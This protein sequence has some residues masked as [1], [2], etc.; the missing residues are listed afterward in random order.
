M[1]SYTLNNISQQKY[2]FFTGKGGVGKTSIA[3]ATAISLADSGENVL[4]I[5]TDPASNLQDVFEQNIS[6]HGTKI[7]DVPRLTVVNL[8]PVEAAE[9]YKDDLAATT[10]TTTAATT[11]IM[12]VG[13]RGRMGWYD[14]QV[15]TCPFAYLSR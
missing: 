15:L 10:I 2:L 3:C 14:A 4:L 1:K 12:L 8:D 9:E 7:K 5:S 11:T 13:I 6:Q